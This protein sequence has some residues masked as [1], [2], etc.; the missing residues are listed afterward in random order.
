MKNKILITSILLLLLCTQGCSLFPTGD[1]YGW[2]EQ[3]AEVVTS[4]NN[5]EGKLNDNI[6][7]KATISE[8]EN[9]DWKE[10]AVSAVKMSEAEYKKIAES[11]KGNNQISETDVRPEDG[12]YCTRY[13]DGSSYICISRENNESRFTYK[14]AK[15]Y[16]F[17]YGDY[18]QNSKGMLTDSEMKNRFSK[19]EIDG[20]SKKEAIKEAV[21]FCRLMNVDVSQEPNLCIAMDK[22][23]GDKML[24][25]KPI[26]GLDKEGNVV[27]DSWDESD[28][29]YYMVFQ[30]SMDNIPVSRH[31]KT[32]NFYQIEE[33]ELTVIVGREGVIKVENN[34]MYSVNSQKS[35]SVIDS[36][37]AMDILATDTVYAAIGGMKL[38]DMSL[39]YVVYKDLKDNAVTIKPM[40]IYTI[41][42]TGTM[43]KDGETYTV[44]NT[45]LGFIDAVTGKVLGG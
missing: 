12:Y 24:K 32:G 44:V 10:Y 5:A 13:S 43:E 18:L 29:A 9:V 40:W 39:E 27:R 3:E 30:Q 15:A 11:L 8:P 35:V 7:V 17:G 34:G 31:G 16:T 23:T 21:E 14:S 45:Q 6:E 33:T 26:L 28:E 41:E 1:T 2:E 38:T 42:R 19:D 37:K 25:D 20:L 4:E 36:K 22:E